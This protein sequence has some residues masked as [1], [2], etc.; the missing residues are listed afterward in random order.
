MSTLVDMFGES[1]VTDCCWKIDQDDTT[2]SHRRC[3]GAAPPRFCLSIQLIK[4]EDLLLGALSPAAN[5]YMTGTKKKPRKAQTSI[6]CTVGVTCASCL[7][8]LSFSARELSCAAIFLLALRSSRAE[9]AAAFRARR[10][11]STCRCR[12]STRCSREE[13]E[14]EAFISCHFFLFSPLVPRSCCLL[15]KKRKW[16]CAI[17]K[18]T[19]EHHMHPNDWILFNSGWSLL[20]CRWGEEGNQLPIG[21]RTLYAKTYFWNT[22]NTSQQKKK[23]NV[24]NVAIVYITTEVANV[25]TDYDPKIV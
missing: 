4:Y 14:E 23:K 25:T 5:K 7:L 21:G 9:S 3:N 12:D 22:V 11:T 20:N 6:S 8:P 15:S 1:E 10:S 19:W 18:F 17:E 24:K 13:E 16:T 2:S